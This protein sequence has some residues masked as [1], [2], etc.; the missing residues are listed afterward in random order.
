M[1]AMI[2]LSVIVTLFSFWVLG[3]HKRLLNARKRIKTAYTQ[4]DAQFKR[5]YVL[6]PNLV[7]IAQ[8]YIKQE[9]EALE[10][11]IAALNEAVE[12]NALTASHP[13]AGIAILHLSAAEDRLTV[14]MGRMF[15]IAESCAELQSSPAML[16]LTEELNDAENKIAHARQAYN[17]CAVQY[18]QDMESFPGPAIANMFGFQAAELMQA[19]APVL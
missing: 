6:I 8:S 7:E 19:A 12:A 2:V 5:R 17:D 15:A 11:V 4:I 3:V 1:I 9:R 16:R 18:N 14:A 13:L 10:A